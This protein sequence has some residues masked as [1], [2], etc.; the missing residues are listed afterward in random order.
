MGTVPVTDKG[1][2]GWHEQQP[3][4]V[5]KHGTA[6]CMNLYVQSLNFESKV[7]YERQ[8]KEHNE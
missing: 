1:F 8:L 4:H 2:V 7:L 6:Y 3:Q 5:R